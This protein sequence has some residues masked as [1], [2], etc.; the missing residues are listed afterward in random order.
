MQLFILIWIYFYKI[1]FQIS[2]HVILFLCNCMHITKNLI[3]ILYVIVIVICFSAK[4]AQWSRKL[5]KKGIVKR[6]RKKNGKS[7][8]L[9]FLNFG[10]LKDEICRRA[11]MKQNCVYL[12][13]CTSTQAWILLRHLVEFL[14]LLDSKFYQRWWSNHI[15]YSSV[16]MSREVLS[17]AWDISLHF[18]MV[19]SYYGS[20]DG[21]ECMWK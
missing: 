10:H 9:F 4:I 8:T 18:S 12:Y 2:E 17:K 13:I 3:Y 21:L 19:I 7:N 16:I 1:A 5:R 6:K 14:C 20:R 15:F 11:F